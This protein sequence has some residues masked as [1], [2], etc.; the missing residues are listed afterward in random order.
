MRCNLTCHGVTMEL[1]LARLTPMRGIHT[2]AHRLRG[3][4]SI[5][6]CSPCLAYAIAGVISYVTNSDAGD[7]LRN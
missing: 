1:G 2:M 7:Y 6:L 4:I 3:L 5:F